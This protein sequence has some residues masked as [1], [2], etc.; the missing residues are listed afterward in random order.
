MAVRVDQAGE[1]GLAA[2]IDTR[3]GGRARLSLGEQLCDLAVITNN[4]AGEAHEL[5]LR[6]DLDAV[7]IVD[8][9]VGQRGGGEGQ[10]GDQQSETRHGSYL[11]RREDV[12]RRPPPAACISA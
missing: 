1:Q 8:Q 5:A 10:R 7:G 11:L 9:R 6:I 12:S 4:N 3:V 2:H